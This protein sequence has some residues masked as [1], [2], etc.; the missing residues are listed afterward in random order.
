MK[1]SNNSL[2]TLTF[3]ALVLCFSGLPVSTAVAGMKYQVYDHETFEKKWLPEGLFQ[4]TSRNIKKSNCMP[5]AK[6]H[7]RKA[8]KHKLNCYKF[9]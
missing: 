5:P 1:T 8:R 9:K 6:S 2:P 3:A 4:K 7:S